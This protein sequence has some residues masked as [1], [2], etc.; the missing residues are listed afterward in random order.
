MRRTLIAAGAVVLILIVGLLT[1]GESP[2]GRSGRLKGAIPAEI[3]TSKGEALAPPPRPLGR[4]K[5]GAHTPVPRFVA[6]TAPEAPPATATAT[7][8]PRLETRG[9]GEMKNKLGYEPPN[10]KETQAKVKTLLRTLEARANG[11]LAGY[12]AP[13]PALKQGVMLAIEIDQAGLQAVSIKDM[14]DI[15]DG[16]VRCLSD[17]AYELDWSGITE[18]P[19][20]LTVPH[21][22]AP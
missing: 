17:A 12:S 9:S 13:D 18:K 2:S 16:P 8:P 11:C 19:V 1:S 6:P 10:F 22:Y 3:P 15:P 7:P 4:Y 14:V 20:M 21:K 5:P